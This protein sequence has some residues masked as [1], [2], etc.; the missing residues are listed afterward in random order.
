VRGVSHMQYREQATLALAV[1]SVSAKPA[2]RP[3]YDMQTGETTVLCIAI[4]MFGASLCI[5]FGPCV[6]HTPETAA[7][8]KGARSILPCVLVNL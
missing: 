4:A 6:L 2:P 1:E 8:T 5:M 7:P 3:V